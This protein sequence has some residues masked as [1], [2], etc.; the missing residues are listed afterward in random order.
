MVAVTVLMVTSFKST[1]ASMLR[2]PGPLQLVPL[3]P[4][5][6]LST[7]TS[8]KDS[9]TVTDNMAHSLVRSPLLSLGPGALSYALPESVSLGLLSAFAGSPGWEIFVGPGTLA[10]VQGRL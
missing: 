2:L 5:R 7:H 6:P 10:T 8:T 1:D 4:S 3:T 9:Q